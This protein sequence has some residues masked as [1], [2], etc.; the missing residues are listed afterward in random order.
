MG[1]VFGF[2]KCCCNLGGSVN[3]PLAL[4]GVTKEARLK[5]VEFFTFMKLLVT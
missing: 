3:R 4:G 1:Y 2:F 5:P